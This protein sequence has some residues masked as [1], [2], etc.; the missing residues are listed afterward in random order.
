MKSEGLFLVM[1]V[2]NLFLH[3]Y[4]ISEDTKL[5]GIE[6][7][8]NCIIIRMHLWWN[9]KVSAKRVK[10]SLEFDCKP[11]FWAVNLCKLAVLPLIEYTSYL[12]N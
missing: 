8:W 1:A 3:L 11:L 4:V 7:V 5:C 12:R 10:R 9:R 2:I 6:L